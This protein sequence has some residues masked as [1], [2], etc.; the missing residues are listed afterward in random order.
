MKKLMIGGAGVKAT[1][2]TSQTESE[3]GVY[4]FTEGGWAFDRFKRKAKWLTKH[5][6]FNFEESTLMEGRALE[7]LLEVDFMS[8]AKQGRIDR[9]YVYRAI[10]NALTNAA[11]KVSDDRRVWSESRVSLDAP[12]GDGEDAASLGEFV[13]THGDLNHQR[14][15]IGIPRLIA[16]R[17]ALNRHRKNAV[18]TRKILARLAE[19]AGALPVDELS[20]EVEEESVGFASSEEETSEG[21]AAALN[22]DEVSHDGDEHAKAVAEVG[23]FESDE[24]WKPPVQHRSRSMGFGSTAEELYEQVLKVDVGL[25]LANLEGEKDREWCQRVIDGWDPV[26]AYAA[27][28]FTKSDFYKKL[29]PRLQDAFGHL[30]YALGWRRN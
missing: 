16:C 4:E 30:G 29:R 10:D 26:V 24:D 12:M 3:S 22:G 2:E 7:K 6:R 27:L 20:E 18:A 13:S 17:W 1:A 25:V 14:K 9:G 15:A 19:D 23:Y 21:D 28:G 5:N 11:Q 8:L